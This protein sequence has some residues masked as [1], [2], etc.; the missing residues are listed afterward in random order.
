M[1]EVDLK[2]DDRKDRVTSLGTDE[3]VNAASES[4]SQAKAY[5]NDRSQSL[6]VLSQHVIE[7]EE[8]SSSSGSELQV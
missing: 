1:T 4:Y 7:E 8:S 3:S 5:E 2:V 6:S